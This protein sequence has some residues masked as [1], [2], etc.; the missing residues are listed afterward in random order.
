MANKPV[1][2]EAGLRFKH[3]SLE[4]DFRVTS[5]SLGNVYYR[6]ELPDGN[7]GKFYKVEMDVFERE[8]FAESL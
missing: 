2:L 3:Q 5:V 1:N 8:H 7:L 6:P 4:G